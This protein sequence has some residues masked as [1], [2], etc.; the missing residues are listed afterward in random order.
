VAGQEGK[1]L[2]GDIL[3]HAG[4]AD[5]RRSPDPSP[6]LDPGAILASIGEVAYEW[7]IGSD[8]LIW[9]PNAAP[10]LQVADPQSIYSGRAY[11]LLIDGKSRQT[12]FEAVM[13]SPKADEGGGVTYQAEYALR[14]ANGGDNLWVEDTGRWFAGADG[15]PERAHGVV[16][17]INERYE[18]EQRLTYLSN[19]DGLTG[20]M[21]RW[22]TT[23]VLQAA[24]DEAVRTRSVCGFLLAAVDNLGRIN[25][26]YGVEVADE[27][28]AGVAKRMRSQLRGKDH[29]GR[30]SGNKFGII[31]KNCT[32]DDM[33]IAADRLLAGVRDEVVV[34]AAGSIAATVTIGGVTAPRHARDL[35]ETLARAQDALD[36][37]KAKRRGSFLA[38]RPNLEREALRQQNVRATSEIVTA[39]N[40]RRIFLV[41]EPVV[42]IGSRAPAFYECLMRV[43]RA[44]GTLLTV[45]ELVPHAE[46]LGLVRMLDHRV[47]ELALAELAAA[48]NLKASLN[49]S[50]ASTVDPDWWSALGGMLRTN[51]GVGERLTVEITE[52]SAIQDIDDTRGFVARVKDLGCRIAID[53]F[54]AGYTSFRNLRKLG[55]D[56]VKID[57][58]FVQNLRRSDDDR[59]FVHTLIDLARRL[60]LETVAEWVQDEEAAAMLADWGCDYLQGA[61]VGLASSQRPWRTEQNPPLAASA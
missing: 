44:D 4:A 39:L 18:R 3:A 59:A 7:R 34:T 48:P 12:R 11:A 36:S 37:A 10:V 41:Y 25:D 47:L 21:N 61:L 1:S 23:E 9:G 57:G 51:H 38:Y 16:R 49:V 56:L 15:K 32:P 30:I 33:T 53:D 58:A 27:V 42:A 43:S 20:E 14:P 5:G 24:L 6:A 28:I 35:R 50:A 13:R 2:E 46:R 17:V 26:A 55:V 8:L 22:H 40:E 19:F 60:G 54:G 29:L 45:S 31:M 52:T